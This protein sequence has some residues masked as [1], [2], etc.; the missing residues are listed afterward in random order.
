ME[1]HPSGEPKAEIRLEDGG[2]AYAVR[3]RIFLASFSPSEN[4]RWV[5]TNRFTSLMLFGIASSDEQKAYPLR[6]RISALR[7]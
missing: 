6:A 5:S 4:C 7:H 3:F 2:A 1:V